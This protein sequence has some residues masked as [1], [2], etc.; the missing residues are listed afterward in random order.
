MRTE[1]LFILYCFA[2]RFLQNCFTQFVEQGIGRGLSFK[3]V[4]WWRE[5]LS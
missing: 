5:I 4:Q 3:V 2:F 1:L